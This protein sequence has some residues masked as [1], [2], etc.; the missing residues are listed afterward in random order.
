MIKCYY[1]FIWDI[2][3]VNPL[4]FHYSFANRNEVY[5]I[6][7]VV[8]RRITVGSL[9]YFAKR[10]KSVNR[11]CSKNRCFAHVLVQITKLS[12]ISLVSIPT[13][14]TRFAKLMY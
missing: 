12:I 11:K 1:M 13:N 4:L 5:R 3:I 10:T 2:L 14:C 7:P 6:S 9:T 8:E